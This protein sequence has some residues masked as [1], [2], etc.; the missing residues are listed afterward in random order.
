[1]C[2][3]PDLRWSVTQQRWSVFVSTN[4]DK[5]TLGNSMRS[6]TL[7]SHITSLTN[8]LGNRIL[9]SNLWVAVSLFRVI[10]SHVAVF[11]WTR[12]CIYFNCC[13]PIDKLLTELW[14]KLETFSIKSLS[15][16]TPLYGN[17]IERTYLGARSWSMVLFTSSGTHANGDTFLSYVCFRGLRYETGGRCFYTHVFL[18]SVLQFLRLYV[19]NY[20]Y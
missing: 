17:L 1:M 2:L 7:A 8:S 4:I 12:L 19:A 14:R 9:L 16:A 5:L 20:G 6:E 3:F 10:A 11:T 13:S 18:I 15:C